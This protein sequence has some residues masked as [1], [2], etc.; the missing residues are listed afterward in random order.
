MAVNLTMAQLGAARL[1]ACEIRV[2]STIPMAAGF[3]SSA[4]ISIAIIRALAAFTGR[5]LTNADVSS[6][7]FQVE[8]RQHGNPSGID[9]TVIA[10]GQPIY[11]VRGQPFETLSPARSFTLVIGDSGVQSSTADVVGD[12]K[13]LNLQSP[14]FTTPAFE[15][16]GDISR[17][18]RDLIQ[19]G[20]VDGL[21]DLMNQNQALL[22]SLTISSPEL[23]R[24]VDAARAAGAIGAKL[25]GGG[26]GGNMIAL[27]TPQT[28]ASVERA[29][30]AAGAVR[31]WITT[32]RAAE[33]SSGETNDG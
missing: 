14:G 21:G 32:V 23:D 24:L 33:G 27:V 4:A 10:Y 6:I 30:Q 7:A 12:I 13:Q 1:P 8:Q 31:T 16:I 9:N 22:R 25:S 2:S 3:G 19:T 18:A 5:T 15:A 17:K 28:A 26:R 11:Y 20:Q 29:M